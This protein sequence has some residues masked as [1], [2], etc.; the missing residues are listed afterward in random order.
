MAQATNSNPSFQLLLTVTEQ[1]IQELGCKKTTL[2]EI[3]N[4]SGLSKGAIYH[5]VK[6]KD[7]LF[8]LILQAR[9][10]HVNERFNE[11]VS[12]AKPGELSGPLQAITDNMIPQ[13]T[14]EK[15]IS[16]MI[17]VYLLGQRDNPDIQKILQQVHAY[18]LELGEKWIKIGQQHHVI[19]ENLD[20]QQIASMLLL[21][22]YGLRV[23]R[24]VNPDAPA[25]N[26]SQIFTMLYQIL[27][28]ET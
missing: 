22:M 26:G 8:G 12:K 16:N 2:Q 24:M 10:Q 20:A 27:K 21:F 3:M 17:F 14:N 13:I 7:E 23:Q 11:A 15:D 4:R 25:I 19:P 18:S 5:Y 6:S 1:T 28:N 9:I